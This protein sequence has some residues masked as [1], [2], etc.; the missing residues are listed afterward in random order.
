MRQADLPPTE[1]VVYRFFASMPIDMIPLLESIGVLAS[2][3]VSLA[4]G[5]T[6]L[7]RAGS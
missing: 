2:Q 7:D 6:V 1:S 3:L 5:S 4:D